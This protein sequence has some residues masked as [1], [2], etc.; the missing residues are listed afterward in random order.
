MLLSVCVV[1]SAVLAVTG[2]PV[3]YSGLYRMNATFEMR[4][5]MHAV[6]YE[7][8]FVRATQPGHLP[9]FSVGVSCGVSDQ[10]CHLRAC[11]IQDSNGHV[12][13]GIHIGE[14]FVQMSAADADASL[15]FGRPLTVVI[16]ISPASQTRQLFFPPGNV[17]AKL[18]IALNH[19]HVPCFDFLLLQGIDDE[20]KGF[21]C[22]MTSVTSYRAQVTCHPEGG[23]CVTQARFPLV[24][25]RDSLTLM[26]LVV[27]EFRVHVELDVGSD[28]IESIAAVSPPMHGVSSRNASVL[29]WGDHGGTMKTAVEILLFAGV[30]PEQLFCFQH[31]GKV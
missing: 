20:S 3:Q 15:A 17:S 28:S 4:S 30:V 27:Y 13:D 22:L 21:V 14:A 2:T 25:F 9:P 12:H 1:V 26:Q 19:S 16:C 6:S 5:G 8:S 7:E 10:L 24:V 23:G 29:V 31:Q 11:S 18:A